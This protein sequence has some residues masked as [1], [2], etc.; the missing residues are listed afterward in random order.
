MLK[1]CDAKLLLRNQRGVFLGFRPRDRQFRP[2]TGDFFGKGGAISI[3]E[4]K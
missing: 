2:Q 3:H 1:L 4:A